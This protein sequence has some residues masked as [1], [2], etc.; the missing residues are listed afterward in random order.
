MIGGTISRVLIDNGD[1]GTFPNLDITGLSYAVTETFF[2]STLFSGL[3][4]D[5]TAALLAGSDTII[6]SAGDDRLLGFDGNDTLIGGAGGDVLD[7]G[8]GINTASYSTAASGLLADL[9]DSGFNTGDAK[10][11]SY[12]AIQNLAG[13]AFADILYGDRGDNRLTGGG[14]NDILVGQAGADTFDGGAGSDTVAYDVSFAVRADLLNPA[15]NTG[16]AA[17]DSYISIENFDGSSFDDILFGNNNANVIGGN[18]YHAT[19]SGNDQLFGRGGNDQLFGYDG[20]DTLDGGAGADRMTGGTGNDIYFVDN[21]GDT[22]IE[23][24]NSGTDTVHSA[25]SYTLP[26]NVENLILTGAANIN[27]AGNA[28]ANAVTGNAGR[29]VLD[30]G[31]GRDTVAG[32][33][34]K[35]VFVFDTPLNAST[36]IDRITDFAHGTDTIRLA[37]ADFTALA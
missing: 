33:A 16:D 27:G 37:H 18:L 12:I 35:D 4:F 31:A 11:D 14:G 21:P 32:G 5:L 22:V 17:G 9:D 13:S 36:N 25:I 3:I 7:G 28:A 26:A 30:G 29:N 24:A 19:P 6:G 10:G 1:V 8:T 20:N 23:A 2:N 34:G 15:T